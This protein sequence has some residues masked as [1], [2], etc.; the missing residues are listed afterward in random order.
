METTTSS[1]ARTCTH[2]R[3]FDADCPTP[4]LEVERVVVLFV[5][6]DSDGARNV[7]FEAAAAVK[8]IFSFLLRVCARAR[9]LA[10]RAFARTGLTVDWKYPKKSGARTPVHTTRPRHFFNLCKDPFWDYYL[11]FEKERERP[12]FEHL[13]SALLLSFVFIIRF[14][15]K[16]N[17][18]K[19]K[20]RGAFVRAFVCAKDAF[21]NTTIHQREGGMPKQGAWCLHIALELKSEFVDKFLLKFAELAR[22]VEANEP[23]TLSYEIGR[24]DQIPNKFIIVERYA[25]KE[26]LADPHQTSEPFKKFKEWM[27]ANEEMFVSKEGFSFYEQQIGYMHR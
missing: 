2:R 9:C 3:P 17:K 23:D 1:P 21:S 20:E 6:A 25:K 16:K 14:P 8:L 27:N 7:V 13:S 15:P 12:F 22:H 24:S 5:V 10:C 4:P 11:G 18:T 26:H 19:R